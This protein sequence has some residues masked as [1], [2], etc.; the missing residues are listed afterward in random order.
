LLSIFTEQGKPAPKKLNPGKNGL[1]TWSFKKDKN[2]IV[3]WNSV[4]NDTTAVDDSGAEYKVYYSH[5]K[6]FSMISACAV[7]YYQSREKIQFLGATK[8]NALEV[9]LPHSKGF[10]N[11]IAVL[12]RTSASPIKEIVY[13]PTEVLISKAPR[14]GGGL[15]LFWILAVSLFVAVAVAIYFWKKK[16][17]VET[18]LNYEMSDVRNVASVASP[19]GEKRNDP[20][21]ALSNVT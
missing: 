4:E 12:P 21:S 15:L 19:I 16:R 2:I 14:T 20:Y 10:I 9:T 13:D 18:I 11:V 7:H 1:L 5:Q 17:R 8:E 3:S 6:E